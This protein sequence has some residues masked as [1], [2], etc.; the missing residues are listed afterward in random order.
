MNNEKELDQLFSKGFVY[1]PELGN[2]P[3]ISIDDS[4]EIVQQKN[5]FI[6]ELIQEDPLT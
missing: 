2:V 3:L 4:D 5:E 6:S 1:D